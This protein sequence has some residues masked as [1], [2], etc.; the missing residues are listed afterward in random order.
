MFTTSKIYART[1]HIQTAERFI[2]LS[3]RVLLYLGAPTHFCLPKTGMTHG[4]AET[5]PVG[6]PKLRE[7]P[8]WTVFGKFCLSVRPRT[9]IFLLIVSGDES[10]RFR[11]GISRSVK[12]DWKL[13]KNGDDYSS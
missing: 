6:G 3:L 12:I 4:P 11:G 1:L 10:T 5:A 8:N 13:G 7:S 2:L 9:F